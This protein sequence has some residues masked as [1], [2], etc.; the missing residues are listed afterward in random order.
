MTTR[1]KPPEASGAWVA[2]DERDP[3]LRVR[4]RVYGDIV[5]ISLRGPLDVYTVP[6][7]VGHLT[8]HRPQTRVT[9]V[10]L[11]HVTFIDSS[12]FGALAKL[13]FSADGTAG[14]LLG[15]ICPQPHLRRAFDIVAVGPRL[16]VGRDTDDLNAMLGPEHRLSPAVRRDLRQPPRQPRLQPAPMR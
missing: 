4:I 10:D 1:L 13:A 11:T 9:V 14:P 12:G 6:T 15:V 8:P 3:G 2:A 7:L 16:M 5:V